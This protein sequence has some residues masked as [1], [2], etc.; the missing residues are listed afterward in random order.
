[1]SNLFKHFQEG[2]FPCGK[3]YVLPLYIHQ[4]LYVRDKDELVN[5]VNQLEMSV[6]LLLGH[7]HQL[8]YRVNGGDVLND[9]L[10]AATQFITVGK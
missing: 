3:L 10:K 4:A 5:V 7:K 8:L 6:D 1:M 2:R 9:N